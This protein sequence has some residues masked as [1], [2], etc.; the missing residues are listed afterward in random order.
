M[1]THFVRLLLLLPIITQG[2]RV[3]LRRVIQ[4]DE[5]TSRDLHNH[6]NDQ[7]CVS[8]EQAMGW[9]GASAHIHCMSNSE[10]T[11]PGEKCL[12][13][14]YGLLFFCGDPVVWD[15]AVPMCDN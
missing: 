12:V 13:E 14:P 4:Q 10:C 3:N 9:F 5:L 2:K 15:Q 11:N 1:K 6:L 8:C 7:D